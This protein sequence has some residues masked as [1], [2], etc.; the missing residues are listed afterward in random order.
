MNLSILHNIFFSLSR[1]DLRSSKRT[2]GIHA[3]IRQ[4][5]SLLHDDQGV[6]TIRSDGI[7]SAKVTG[8]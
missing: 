3:S 4:S 2:S 1:N 6:I 8:G 7:G 5:L